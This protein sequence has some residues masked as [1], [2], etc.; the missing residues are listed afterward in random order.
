MK[1]WAGQFLWFCDEQNENNVH[2]QWQWRVQRAAT[3]FE[4]SFEECGSRECHG[5]ACYG[6]FYLNK[7]MVSSAI[8]IYLQ[9]LFIRFLFLNFILKTWRTFHHTFF[10]R[11]MNCQ[12]I[13]I[14]YLFNRVFQYKQTLFCKQINK[15]L[16][17][18]WCFK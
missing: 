10:L 3:D 15:I 5:T 2:A 13:V 12:N 4:Q 11:F 7:V 1:F 17:I 16:C 18:V 8:N 6:E 14:W 9:K